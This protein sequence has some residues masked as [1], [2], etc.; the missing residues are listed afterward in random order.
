MSDE[1]SIKSKTITKR[2][3]VVEIANRT[4]LTQQ[5]VFDVIQYTMDD[6]TN[7]LALGNQVV[8]RNF[9]TFQVRR[10]K[11]KIGRN[12]NQPG[13]DVV[14]P[15]RSVVKFKPGKEMKERVEGAQPV[16]D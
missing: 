6:I 9:G 14:I 8:M 5:K 16:I 13:T 15:P 11:K 10:T 2:D 3:L 12:P 1:N 7:H 4:G